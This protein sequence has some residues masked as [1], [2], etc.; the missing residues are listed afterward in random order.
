MAHE[1]TALLIIDF[2]NPLDFEG[3][4]ELAP[5]AVH[6]ARHTA[7]L[8][9]RLDLHGVPA[10]YANDNFGHWDSDFAAVVRTCRERGGAAAEMALLLEP[11]RC[12]RSVLKPRHSAFFGTPLEF[13]LDEMRIA[14]LVLVGIS[15][16][17]CVMFTAHDAYLRKYR[18][19]VPRDCVAA[20]R[21]EYT[22]ASLAHMARVLR[23]DTRP[24]DAPM[25]PW[26]G[27]SS[28][29]EQAAR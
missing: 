10:I 11:R 23:A 9:R 8:R 15:A 25:L 1:N 28:D 22:Q 18:M 24:A 6:A 20:M 7:L 5:A 3:G 26:L 13:L 12:D 29:Q 27:S 19:W 14:N 21:P 2:M 16:D 17:S 4:A